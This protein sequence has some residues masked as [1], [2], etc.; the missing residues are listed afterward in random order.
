[1]NRQN[2]VVRGLTLKS[3]FAVLL[4]LLLGAAGASQAEQFGVHVAAGV[5]DHHVRTL[6]LGVV[7]DP[8]LTWWQIGDWHFALLG[9]AHVAWWH[10]N[11]GN[12][13]DNIGEI[14]VTPVIRFIRSSGSVRPFIEVGAGVRLLT[15]PRISS[16]F[17]LGTSFQFAEMAGVG[18]QFGAREQYVA[19]YRFQHVSNGGIKEPNPG[20][21]FSQLYL[22]YHF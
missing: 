12:V 7:W 5:G 11:E 14:G 17:T 18:L 19:G 4:V 10:T 9:G 13:H 8:S 6:D 2:L 1:M 3:T 20:I 15:S 22:Q 16:D 21:N